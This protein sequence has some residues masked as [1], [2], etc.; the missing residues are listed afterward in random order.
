M[1]NA[2][3]ARDARKKRNGGLSQCWSELRCIDL[4]VLAPLQYACTCSHACVCVY[5]CCRLTTAVASFVTALF[6]LF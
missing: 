1:A 4:R 5:V 3:H 6:A 2:M